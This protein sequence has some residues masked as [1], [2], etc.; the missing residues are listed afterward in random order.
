MY[1]ELRDYDRAED[2]LVNVLN[3]SPNDRHALYQLSLLRLALNSTE[4]A[5]VAATSAAEECWTPT[6]I[7]A[8]LHTYLADLQLTL[9]DYHSALMVK[10]IYLY[11]W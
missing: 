7:C 5:V 11:S 6:N 4:E 3:E 1:R 10:F 2:L 8:I 9:S